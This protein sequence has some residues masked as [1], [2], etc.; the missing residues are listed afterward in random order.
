MWEN[1]E[2]FVTSLL[3]VINREGTIASD[4]DCE[5]ILSAGSL[6]GTGEQKRQGCN[7]HRTSSLVGGERGR[8]SRIVD[9]DEF[10]YRIETERTQPN[11]DDHILQDTEVGRVRFDR[12]LL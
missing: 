12:R 11:K 4:A 2:F 7:G 6:I 5:P 8:C 3:C 9:D 1:I 10:N